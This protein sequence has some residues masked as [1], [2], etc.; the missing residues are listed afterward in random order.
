MAASM[1]VPPGP[2][3]GGH[4]VRH[5][6]RRGR[7]D[8]LP[9]HLREVVLHELAVSVVDAS[10][11]GGPHQAPAVGD[12]AHGRGH[13]HRRDAHALPE[14]DGGR[15]HLVPAPVVAQDAAGLAGE[16]QARLLAEAEATHG[17]VEP[18]APHG[19]RDA[20]RADVAREGDDLRRRQVL[21]V[22]RVT[23]RVLFVH[24]HLAVAAV[25]RLVRADGARRP[26]RLPSVKGLTVEPGSKRS[27][28]ARLRRALTSKRPGE[29][30]SKVG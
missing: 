13:L 27:V 23:D 25:E 24:H 4:H 16:R 26:A 8:D 9:T 5:Q 15:V 20:R 14:R 6:A 30:G 19:G 3:D 2:V 28:T 18:A 7:G 10:D 11:Q 22:V 12:G 1:P 21:V 17:A 29:L